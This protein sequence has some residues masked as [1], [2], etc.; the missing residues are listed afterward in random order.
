MIHQP[1]AGAEGAVTDLDIRV[2]EFKKAKKNLNELLARHT[3]QPIE[4][5]SK[6]TDRDH[7]MTA[8]EGKEY[9]LVDD[10]LTS[11]KEE[12]NDDDEK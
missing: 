1:F 5:I 6:D 7:Y 3:G 10:I 8:E 12:E 2:A 4:R 11:Q 9:G